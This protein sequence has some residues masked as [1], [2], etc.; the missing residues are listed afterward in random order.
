M[1]PRRQAVL[2]EW[3]I[4]AVVGAVL[5]K[6]SDWMVPPATAAFPGHGERFV[7]MVND[8][9]A[10][11]GDFPHRVLWPL[12]ANLV[13][14]LGVAPPVFTQVC[15]AA[16]LAVVFWFC[17]QRRAAWLDASLV[18][19]AIA[20]SGAVLVYK[21]MACYSDTLNLLLLVLSVHFVARPIVFW[22]LV[23]LAGLSHEMVFF[24]APWLLWLRVHAGGGTWRRDGAALA[25]TFA[26]YAGWRLFVGAMVPAAAAGAPAASYDAWYYFFHSFWVPWLLPGLW[27]LWLLVVLAEFGPLLALAV[28]SWR[29]REPSMGGRLGLWLY[30]GCVLAMMMLAYDVMRFATFA[31]LPVLLGSL[32]LL[33]Q[34]AMRLWFVGILVASIAT[35]VWQ[36]PVPSQQG[37]AI[38][39][40]VGPEMFAWVIPRVKEGQR[41]TW[42]DAMDV[43]LQSLSQHASVWITV[44]AAAV[45][46]VAL[47]LW[48][49]R[50]VGSASSSGSEPRT[51]R[52]ASP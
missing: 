50:Y 19:A 16:L 13:G 17:R 6:L 37:G 43:Q 46:I 24:F 31:C 42:S 7:A 52:N 49:A 14:R 22:G 18:T 41:V 51:Q 9:F 21:P 3:L 29:C 8:P 23:L 28:V 10:F 5:L 2:L 40:R 35:Y 45:G 4:A 48:L 39:T 20:A 12:L 27:A 11:T 47:G 33:R 32:A 36:H 1:L 34:A 15:N 30:F 38:F 26:L 44:V 25:M